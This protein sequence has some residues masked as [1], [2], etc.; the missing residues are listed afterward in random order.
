M[1]KVLGI[2]ASLS[3]FALLCGVIFVV[4]YSLWTPS[5]VNSVWSRFSLAVTIGTFLVLILGQTPLFAVLCK[6]PLVRSIFPPIDGDW[7]GELISNWPEIAKRAEIPLSDSATKPVAAKLK[8]RAT[9]FFIHIT[10]ISDSK[11]S[12]SKTV[13]VHAT[14]HPESGELRLTYV[15]ENSTLTP[16]QTDS[17]AHHGAAYLDL[18]D[19]RTLEGLYWTNRNYHRALNTAGRIK[20][21]RA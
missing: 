5:G 2:K 7:V 6:L 17:L 18:V 16:E 12:T 3:Y 9:L 14:K 19:D 13:F 11:Y 8:I 15:Y 1:Y 20:L 4:I 21:T 10:L